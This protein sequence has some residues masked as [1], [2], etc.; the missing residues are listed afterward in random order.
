MRPPTKAQ[1]ARETEGGQTL[2]QMGPKAHPR[3]ASLSPH[4][5]ATPD[6]IGAAATPREGTLGGGA[7][8]PLPIYILEVWGL[9]NT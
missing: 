4:L 1:G 8:P 3:C 6:G 7:A 2:G 5:A 9:P